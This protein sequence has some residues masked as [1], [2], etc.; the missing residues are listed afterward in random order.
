MRRMVES[1]N[2]EG[3]LESRILYSIPL[4]RPCEVKKA[5]NSAVTETEDSKTESY[6]VLQ[7]KVTTQIIRDR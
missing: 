6:K 4:Y 5:K 2:Y 3:D 1:I 7:H